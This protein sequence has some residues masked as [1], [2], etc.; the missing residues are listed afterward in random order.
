M[1]KN[2][3]VGKAAP[4]FIM[5]IEKACKEYKAFEKRLANNKHVKELNEILGKSI[6]EAFDDFEL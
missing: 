5:N 4:N 3:V 2:W 1:L 6:Q